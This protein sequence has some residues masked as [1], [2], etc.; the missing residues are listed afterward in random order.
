MKT[1]LVISLAAAV[2]I[3]A[4]A[5]STSAAG[6]TVLPGFRSPS[7][8]IKCF[9]VQKLYCSIGRS[10]YGA[11]LQAGCDLDWHGFQLGAARK[12]EVYCT[13]NAPYDMGKQQPSKRILPYGKRFHHGSFTC[14]SRI[15]G[16]TCHS[17]TGHGLFISRQ[18]Y[19]IW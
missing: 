4:V 5:A 3:A 9:V 7:G 17:R 15:T 14:S 2:V 11:R 8:N 18:A 16:V 12:A 6:R 19:R 13:S 10:D 1:S